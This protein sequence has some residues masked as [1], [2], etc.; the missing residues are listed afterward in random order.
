MEW[1]G[2]GG[3][4]TPRGE[5]QEKAAE[6]GRGGGG[7]GGGRPND[8]AGG[9]FG[10]RGAG[11]GG[12]KVQPPQVT[13]HHPR[14]AAIP[15]PTAPSTSATS[16]FTSAFRLHKSDRPHAAQRR[17]HHP[18]PLHHQRHPSRH[19][20][21]V[22]HLWRAIHTRRADPHP[23]PTIRQPVLHTQTQVRVRKP[24][25]RRRSHP[26]VFARVLL[27]IGVAVQAPRAEPAPPRLIHEAA[28]GPLGIRGMRK[29]AES[30]AIATATQE[31]GAGRATAGH[32][33]RGCRRASGGGVA[34]PHRYR[35]RHRP[36]WL[37]QAQQRTEPP[38]PS[39]VTQTRVQPNFV[40]P[41]PWVQTE[42]A[43][44]R[45]KPIRGSPRA[46]GS[47]FGIAAGGYFGRAGCFGVAGG[48]RV[49]PCAVRDGRHRLVQHAQILAE[50]LGGDGGDEA[51][52]GQKGGGL[53][54]LLCAPGGI[55]VLLRPPHPCLGRLPRPPRGL[56]AGRMPRQRLPCNLGSPRLG[57]PN[58]L[59]VSHHSLP[60]LIGSHV[61][62]QLILVT[63][64]TCGAATEAGQ[65]LQVQA[66][67][68]GAVRDGQRGGVAHAGEGQP[69]REEAGGGARIDQLSQ[70]GGSPLWCAATGAAPGGGE[71]GEQPHLRQLGQ[72]VLDAV[73]TGRRQGA[74]EQHVWGVGR[75]GVRGAAE[76]QA[77]LVQ[78]L[79]AQA[80]RLELGQRVVELGRDE[81]PHHSV[82]GATGAATALEGLGFRGPDQAGGGG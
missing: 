41:S 47:H 45:T 59:R 42:G 68:D 34:P 66:R 49:S 79:E 54:T 78:R 62:D 71:G 15:T 55:L 56:R 82:V 72:R 77:L 40:R 17:R 30:S 3:A 16:T 14:Y 28:D 26:L 37:Q 23:P 67:E 74:V 36:L 65:L 70:G 24:C 80:G 60:Q 69:F 6:S 2:G 7:G 9:A 63:H 29:R 75:A 39:F 64:S 43:G 19:K 73:L 44:R 57:A 50:E 52:D 27:R 8:E 21:S 4:E 53:Q 46:A 32:T 38:A 25:R 5:A 58:P 76:H 12:G 11:G 81:A 61:C 18:L 31:E 13:F 1:R 48:R 51:A 33:A 10:Q 22:F 20:A 35:R